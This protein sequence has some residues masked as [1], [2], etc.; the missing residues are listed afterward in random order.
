MPIVSHFHARLSALGITCIIVENELHVQATNHVVRVRFDDEWREGF[1]KYKSARSIA[2]IQDQRTLIHNNAVEVQLIRLGQPQL[3]MA[4][5]FQLKDQQGNSVEVGVASHV[6]GLSFFDSSEYEKYFAARVKK[7]LLESTIA[8]RKVQQL[9]WLPTTATYTHKGRKTPS[10]LEARANASVRR[11]LFK[12]AFEQHDCLSVW[13]PRKRRLKSLYLDDQSTDAAIPR[14][15]YD[16]NVVS[17]YKVAKASPFPSQSFLAYYH[18]LEYFFLRVSEMLL[19]DRLSAMI[20][21]PSFSVNRSGLDKVISAVRGQDSR[22]DETEML[23]NV[24]DRF[25]SEQDLIEFLV[26]FEE[27]CGE[28]IYT[29]RRQVFGEQMQITPQKDH[30]LANASKVLKHVRNAIVHS[31]DRYKREDCHIPLSETED[32]VEEFIPLV[33]FLAERVIFGTAV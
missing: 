19:H 3:F 2:F 1:Q 28:K 16:E 5:E 30:A 7:R 32:I 26:A 12:I 6:Y 17:Y 8:S 4:D 14:A 27:K 21:A 29:K 20:N 11:S 31:S 25:V 33:R 9:L 23:R 18:V 24:L 10:D 22:S 15:E 13:K